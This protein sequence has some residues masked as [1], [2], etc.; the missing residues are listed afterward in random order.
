MAKFIVVDN[1][2][3]KPVDDVQF[4]TSEEAWKH[5]DELCL[6]PGHDYDPDSDNEEFATPPPP[7]KNF[8]VAKV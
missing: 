2:D 5:A 7:E 8:D 6:V 4:D 3:N 1:F